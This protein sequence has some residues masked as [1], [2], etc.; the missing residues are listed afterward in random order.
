MRLLK[1]PDDSHINPGAINRFEIKRHFLG[2]NYYVQMHLDDGRVLDLGAKLSEEEADQLKLDYEQRL[3]ELAADISSYKE[4]RRVGFSNGQKEGYANG[5]KDGYNE[6]RRAGFSDGQ[7]EGYASGHAD[8]YSE[9][10]AAAQLE[11]N[12]S[13]YR[14]GIEE[15]LEQLSSRKWEFNDEMRFE[16]H[17]I[18][19]RRVSLIAMIELIDSVIASFS[20]RPQENLDRQDY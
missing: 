12:G 11:S 14:G 19:S 15:V 16:A 4:G 3:E 20:S 18:E 5:H 1:L 10:F 9:G 8:G 2:K 13:A 17:L 6:G 7:K